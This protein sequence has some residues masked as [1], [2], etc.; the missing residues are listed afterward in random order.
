MIASMLKLT[1]SDCKDLK[2]TDAYSVHRIIYDLFPGENRD[3]LF[4]DKGGD[5]NSRHILI[6]SKREPTNIKKGEIHS[7]KV[8]HE[9]LE[10]F[11]YSFEV[12]LNPTKRD[13]TT[14]KIVAITGRDNLMNWFVK[15]APALGFEIDPDS[16]DISSNGVQKFDLGDGKWVTHNSAVFL[17]KLKVTDRMKFQESFCKGIGRAKGFGFGLFQ[18]S[19]LK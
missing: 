7:K 2:L 5:F 3:F 12:R 18:I 6:L 11:N 17:G 9:F 8:P 13:K 4:A 1:R 16:L 10:Q 14:G 15:K 19:P